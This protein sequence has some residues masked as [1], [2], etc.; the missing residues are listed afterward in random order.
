LKDKAWLE[1]SDPLVEEERSV[2][3]NDMPRVSA[4]LVGSGRHAWFVRAFEV[5]GS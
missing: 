3:E 4:R 5:D 2:E 1:W